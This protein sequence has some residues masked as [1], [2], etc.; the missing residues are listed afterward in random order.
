[1]PST[2]SDDKK[3]GPEK[4]PEADVDEEGLAV[5]DLTYPTFKRHGSLA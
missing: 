5:H 3:W 1:M 2:V 4:R